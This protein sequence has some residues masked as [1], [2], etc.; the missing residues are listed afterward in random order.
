MKFI[1]LGTDAFAAS[2]LE[3]MVADGRT[4]QLVVTKPDSKQGEA[5]AWRLRRLPPRHSNS[6]WRCS[7]RNHRRI[8]NCSTQWPRSNRM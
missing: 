4:P 3:A 6:G 8:R 5:A 7:S 1:Y 2:V